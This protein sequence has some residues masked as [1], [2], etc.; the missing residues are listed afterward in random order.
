LS[1]SLE[2]SFTFC[3]KKLLKN[4]SISGIGSEKS[5]RNVSKERNKSN[6]EVQHDVKQ[7]LCFYLIWETAL[8][9]LT[10]SQNH[11][12]HECI[13]NI[14]NTGGKQSAHRMINGTFLLTQE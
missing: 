2:S 12:R 14:P 10:S 1:L 4:D 7:H 11:H 3:A 8:D 13:N 5:I 6:A 9:L